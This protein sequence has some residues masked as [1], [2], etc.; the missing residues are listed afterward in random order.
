[1]TIKQDFK[2]LNILIKNVPHSDS[3]SYGLTISL[4]NL[5]QCEKIAAKTIIE[6]I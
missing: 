3:E 2:M 6:H 4:K 5:A 1:M